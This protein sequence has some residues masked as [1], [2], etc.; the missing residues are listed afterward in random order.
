MEYVEKIQR[1]FAELGCV[2]P[3]PNQEDWLDE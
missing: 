3:D 1:F 2:I